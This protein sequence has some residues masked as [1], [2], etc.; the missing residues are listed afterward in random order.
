MDYFGINSAEDLPKIKE[1]LA[2]QLVMPT[3]I[4]DTLPESEGEKPQS[5][6]EEDVLLSV[7]ETGELI[8]RLKT[9]NR[10]PDSD[11]RYAITN[12]F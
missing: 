5:S 12:L 3:I 2:E 6:E 10:N 7:T 11:T 1:V 8:E 4:K 9:E